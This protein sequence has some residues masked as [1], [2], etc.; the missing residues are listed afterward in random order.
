MQNKLRL[1]SSNSSKQLTSTLFS[2]SA[3]SMVQGGGSV[4][5]RVVDLESQIWAT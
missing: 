2:K 5:P 4:V 3:T 1:S